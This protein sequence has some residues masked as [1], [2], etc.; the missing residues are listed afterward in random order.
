MLKPLRFAIAL[1]MAFCAL[2][3]SEAAFAADH[4]DAP[5]STADPA[6]DI[7]DLYVWQ[8][9]GT[10]ADGTIVVVLNIDGLRM[11]ADLP[12][13]D[14]D[15]LYTINIDVDEDQ[16][17]DRQIFV[18]FGED[19]VGNVGVQLR[20]VPGN[21]EVVGAVNTIIPIAGGQVFVGP[22][23]DPFFFDFDG[24]SATAARVAAGVDNADDLMFDSTNDTFAGSNVTS[25]VIEFNADV[26]LGTTDTTAAFWATTSRI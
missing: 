5:G 12:M 8:R 26:A 1:A 21:G 22:R 14:P 4:I 17:A 24:F 15:V 18:R 9:N 6:A 19:S 2:G 10:A 13:Y 3:T 20:G 25:I 23:E 7:T 11:P 16:V